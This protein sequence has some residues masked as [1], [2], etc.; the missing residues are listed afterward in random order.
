MLKIPAFFLFTIIL[1]IFPA[2]AQNSN[3]AANRPRPS[4]P[5]SDAGL[6]SNVPLP[7]PPATSIIRGRVYY[8]DT[9][10]AVKRTLIMFIADGSGPG[11]MTGLTDGDGNFMVK[12][13]RAGTYY[14]VVNAPGV[15][16]P[17]AYL[18][19]AKM[20]PGS[21]GGEKESLNEAFVNFDKIVVDGVNEVYVQVPAKRGGAISGR[22][23]YENGD[24]AIGV[25]VE[26]L[27]KVNGKYISVISSLMSIMSMFS[28]GTG[29]QTDDRGMYR[30]SGL[31]AGDYIVKVSESAQHTDEQQ[32]RFG[33]GMESLLFGFSSMLTFYY[34]DASDAK[35]AQMLNVLLG[36][37]QSEINIA[38]PD[39]RL[40][41]LAGKVISQKDKKPLAGAKV[42][43]KKKGQ[44]D[45][46]LFS[47][48]GAEMNVVTADVEGN[49]KFKELPK[50]DYTITVVPANKQDYQD[51]DSPSE[52]NGAANTARPNA[53]LKPTF[54]KSF[55]DAEI[56]DKSIEDL[57]IE[58]G[59]GATVSGTFSVD[60]NK[61]M[62]Q[63]ASIQAFG[64]NDELLSSATVWN[65]RR[66]SSANVAIP[67][68][69][70]SLDFKLENVASGKIN[71]KFQM[72]DDYYI[73]SAR[74]GMLDLMA[75]PLDIKE[76]DLISGVKVVLANDV[77]TLKG[78]IL[79]DKDHA[80]AG[81]ALLL[82]P[83]DTAR[84]NS[85]FYKNVR[86]DTDGRFEIKL[87]P[88]EYAVLFIKP[89]I[90][91]GE[92]SLF[93]AWLDEA[94]KSPEKASVSADGTTNINLRAPGE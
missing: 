65:Y 34:P 30:F 82:V 73:K 13:V 71:L 78:R 42:S 9:G 77:G 90:T 22:V 89:G 91:D 17:V 81:T 48:I 6:A 49:W 56:D 94:M 76:G 84:R 45:S 8:E 80:V 53:P 79:D 31:P 33:G 7:P 51:D 52:Y 23:F 43:L 27:R 12:N 58:L 36:Q 50:G 72:S 68:P 62:P 41:S 15:V 61:D 10:R 40:F 69:K 39:K 75:A 59:Y 60:N 35:D 14:A 54:A 20:G 70:T 1:F 19:F 46:S 66:G 32:Q 2:M 67:T 29:G 25:K 55:K 26:M 64:E 28:G 4:K 88:G 37:E 86:S 92:K 44:T 11:E 57:V 63:N 93:T 21:A 83:T 16:S 38:I 74:S 5:V 3:T 87:P 18:D 47:L 85:N 24:P